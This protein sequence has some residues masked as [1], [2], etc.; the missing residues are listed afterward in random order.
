MTTATRSGVPAS[1]AAPAG[2]TLGEVI[3]SFRP[4]GL[5]DTRTREH[6]QRLADFVR[7]HE[8]RVHRAPS[9][10]RE[11]VRA[12]LGWDD[13][14]LHRFVNTPMLVH[15]STHVSM[16]A[17]APMVSFPWFC[18][19]LLTLTA[20][21]ADGGEG[22]HLRTQLTHNNLSDNRWKPHVWWRLNAQGELARTQL[23]SKQPRFKHQVLL[24]QR[25]PDLTAGPDRPTGGE[26]TP[27]DARAVRLAGHATNFAY[28]AM[29]YR[30][31]LE[32][33]VGLHLPHGTVEIPVDFMNAFSLREGEFPGW[34]R[35]LYGQGFALREIG[36]DHLLR[37]L[38][39]EEAEGLDAPD[40]LRPE[41][42]LI[43]P[44]YINVG[45]AHR[46]G[47]SVAI[48]ADRMASYE[49]EM[50]GVLS[51]FFAGLGEIH[52]APQFLGVAGIG[53]DR[54]LPLPEPLGRALAEQGG[55]PSLPLYA[56]LY[57]DRL[58]PALDAALHQPM[59]EL[60]S[61][62]TRHVRRPRSAPSGPVHP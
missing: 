44:N 4:A 17:F 15:S 7:H 5:P 42:T 43:C 8:S 56:A 52:R 6:R 12:L 38:S 46:M 57:G 60:A 31:A 35:V 61:I 20:G 33:A 50:T 55:K 22:S 58:V 23:F 27:G 1:G 48:G 40:P 39:A 62:V 24:T 45:H 29:M 30:M 47:P 34:R 54:L 25:V 19:R 59:G 28:F 49:Q 2:P 14:S 10:E 3:G 53:L 51:R 18:L 41:A 11:E 16:N 13:A 26:L 9:A 36:R 32:R 37:E 21:S